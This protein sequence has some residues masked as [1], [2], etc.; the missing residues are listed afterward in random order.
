MRAR[1]FI[2]EADVGKIPREFEWA[3]TGIHKFRDQGGFDRTNHLYKVMQVAGC[4]DGRTKEAVKDFDRES[5]VGKYNTAHPYTEMEHN[6]VIG[7]LKTIGADSGHIVSDHRSFEIPE[8]NRQSIV[9][10][11]KRKKNWNQQ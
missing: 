5:W 7:A 4:H 10:T 9:P 11:A 6:M 8:V 2:T 1:E 3:S